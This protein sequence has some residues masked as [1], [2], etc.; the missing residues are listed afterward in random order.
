MS[1]LIFDVF[2]EIA[3]LSLVVFYQLYLPFSL[4]HRQQKKNLAEDLERV[5]NGKRS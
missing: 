3:F 2:G 1:D 4:S 5:S